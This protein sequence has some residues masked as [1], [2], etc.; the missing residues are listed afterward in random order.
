MLPAVAVGAATVGWLLAGPVA[1][2]AVGTY[3]PVAV[4]AWRRHRAR[5]TEERALGQALDA[6]TMLAADLRAG[7]A[8]AVALTASMPAVEPGSRYGSVSRVEARLRAALRVADSLGAP[9]ADVC[10]RLDGDLRAM[11][12]AAA[13]ARAH[14]AGAQA[15]TLLLAALP[16]AG[17][18]LGYSIGA[19]PLKVLLHTTL[20]AACLAAAMALHLAGLYWSERLA[21]SVGEPR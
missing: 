21:R 4:H 11:R 3:A 10:D 8:P 18:A 16:V 17:I 5:L 1:A 20:G 15:T 2:A 14:A 19:D 6:V 7:T 9:L 13:L 12:R